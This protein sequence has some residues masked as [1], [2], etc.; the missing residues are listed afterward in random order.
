MHGAGKVEPASSAPGSVGGAAANATKAEEMQAAEAEAKR[1]RE[2][3]KDLE[4]RIKFRQ[5]LLEKEA[6]E[7]KYQEEKVRTV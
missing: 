4:E 6:A 2:R 5:E 3:E 1:R 7:T